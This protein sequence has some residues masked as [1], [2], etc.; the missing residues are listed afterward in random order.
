MSPPPLTCPQCG[1]PMNRHAELPT[2][3]RDANEAAQAELGLG[4]VL[5]ETHQCPR[6]G[7]IVA[8]RGSLNSRE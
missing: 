8:R 4:V 6:C 3:P 2:E 5:E 1:A 7:A